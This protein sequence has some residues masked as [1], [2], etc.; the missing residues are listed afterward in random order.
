MKIK[1]NKKKILALTLASSLFLYRSVSLI[2]DVY[3]LET[4]NSINNDMTSSETVNMANMV[5]ENEQLNQLNITHKV[6]LFS[7]TGELVADLNVYLRKGP[8]VENEKL[9]L[10]YGSDKVIAY[11]ISENGWYL[12]DYNGVLGFASSEYLTS[13][14]LTGDSLNLVNDVKKNISSVI[15]IIEKPLEQSLETVANSNSYLEFQNLEGTIYANTN[16]NF[17]EAADYNSKKID[18]I[19]KGT[20]LQLL[21]FENGWYLVG[22]KG[23]FGYVLSKYVSYD[24]ESTYRDDFVDV[25]YITRETPLV[26][27]SLKEETAKY[28]FTTYE[29]CEVLGMSGEWYLVRYGDLYGC[30]KKNCTSKIANTAVVVDIDDQRLVLYKNNK[31][32]VETDV[33]TGTFGLFDTPTGIFSIRNKV[34]DTSLVSEEYG[35]NQPVDYWMPFNGGIGL[36]DASWRSKFG[37]EIYIKDGSHGC[38][39]IPPKYADDVFGYV[40]IGTKVLVHR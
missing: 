16:V 17:R 13:L 20:E 29:V 28:W 5:L 35:Y 2:G 36:H 19:K 27:M 26:D 21:G 11:G 34:M 39:N 9:N 24:R 12:V 30:V 8:G 10:I 22:Y 23:R 4:D 15:E 33:V 7:F 40:N 6:N 38:V 1:V 3:A 32:I 37:G 31:I 18:L 25:V 14:T